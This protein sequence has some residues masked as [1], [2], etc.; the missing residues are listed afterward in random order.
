MMMDKLQEWFHFLAFTYR[1]YVDDGCQARAGSLTY[2]T[3]FA[4]VPLLTVVY[5]MLSL[6]PAFSAVGVQVQDW[7]FANFLPE[8]GADVKAALVQFSG[9]ARSLTAVGLLFLAATAYFMLRNIEKT[10][11]GIW[12]TRTDRRGLA[13][14]LLYWAL[15]SLGP[16]LIGLGFVISTYLVS[17][18]IFA[19]DTE[20]LG[21]GH[22]LLAITPFLLEATTFTLIF[23]AV[24]NAK[25]RVK[26]ALIGGLVTA[27]AFETAKQAFA[28]IVKHSSFTLIYG[29]FAAVPL[30]L[31][32]INLSWLIILAGAE[33]VHA[34]GSYQPQT[35]KRYHPLLTSVGLMALFHERHQRGE[36]VSDD[37]IQGTP[38]MLGKQKLPARQ[39][40]ELRNAMLAN[41]LIHTTAEGQYILGKDLHSFSLWDLAAMIPDGWQPLNTSGLEPR[42]LAAREDTP[43]W[44]RHTRKLLA[45]SDT[46]R[47]HAMD[48]SIATLVNRQDANPEAP[49]VTSVS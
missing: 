6:V 36:T 30:F 5:V 26:H 22:R 18:S 8:T 24:P 43:A 13:N 11:N 25:V 14:F 46:T 47:H 4:V 28:L 42:A 19:D 20:G 39:W 44:Y 33:L 40:H 29:T 16:L 17:L 31:L 45:D 3:L 7:I 41:G 27:I 9:Q 23:L 37:E 12:H 49:C 35:A 15:L 2:L 1:N 34:L 32:W 21:I 48:A 38:W 10:M